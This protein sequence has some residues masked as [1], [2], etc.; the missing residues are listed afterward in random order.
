MPVQPPDAYQDGAL[1]HTVR[2]EL[3]RLRT[4]ERAWDP[5]TIALIER[6][7]PQPDWA[8]LELGAGAGSIARWLAGRCP[9][10]QVTATDLDTGYLS[11]AAPANLRVLRHDVTAENFPDDGFDL[12][13]ARALLVHLPQRQD[14]LRRATRWLKP[15]GRLLVEDPAIFPVDSSPHPVFQKVVLGGARLLEATLGTDLRW[16]RTMPR[17][18]VQAGLTAPGLRVNVGTVGDGGPDD[19]LWRSTFSQARDAMLQHALLTPEDAAELDGLLDSPTFLD[20]CLAQV[21]S[22]AQRPANG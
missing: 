22:W 14:V 7:A 19:L 12:I 6:L 17:P 5:T 9:R 20:V 11:G 15:G 3:D 8:C 10:G 16:P 21:S 13:H 2:T 4:L 1:S 18:L